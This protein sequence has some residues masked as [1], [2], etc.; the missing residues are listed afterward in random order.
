MVRLAQTFAFGLE[1]YE[2]SNT[3][4]MAT[5]KLTQPIAL[6]ILLPM[7][8]PEI[9]GGGTELVAKEEE[10]EAEAE[11]ATPFPKL[12]SFRLGYSGVSSMPNLSRLSLA[13]SR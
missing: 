11:L 5:T 6:S 7:L 4:A 10:E 1:D 3:P 2:I 13:R 8:L 9:G 12:K